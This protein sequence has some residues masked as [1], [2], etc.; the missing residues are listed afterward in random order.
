MARFDVYANRFGQGFLIDC[1]SNVVSAMLTTRLV[2]P[3]LPTDAA[4]RPARRLNPVFEIEGAPYVMVTQ[5]AAAVAVR[6]LG[7]RV[8]SLIEQD[9]AIIGAIDMLLSGY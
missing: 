9:I 8:T 1:Q 3:L 7:E 4:P 5:F 2:V 6:D